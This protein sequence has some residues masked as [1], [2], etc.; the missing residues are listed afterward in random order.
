M[1]ERARIDLFGEDRGHEQFFRPLLE[2]LAKDEGLDV[3]I[4]VVSA[5]GGHPR[6]LDA[7]RSFQK[8]LARGFGR[9]PDLLVVVRDANRENWRNV[10]NDVIR[11]IDP[12]VFPRAVVACPAPYVER[13]CIADPAAFKKIVG[14]EPGRDPDSRDREAYKRLFSAAIHKAG[15]PILIDEMDLAPD[16]VA[17]MDFYVAGKAQPSLKHCMEDL[18]GAL[19]A[20]AAERNG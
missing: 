20:L 14:V 18:R 6:A 7:L 12:A 16:L 3:E 10:K 11:V 2:R 17:A 1:A 8:A 5:S 19:R 13:W 15:I 9:T 4:H